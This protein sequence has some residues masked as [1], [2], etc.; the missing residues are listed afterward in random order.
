M[1]VNLRTVMV[2][3][4]TKAFPSIHFCCSMHSARAPVSEMGCIIVRTEQ[5]ATRFIVTISWAAG[6]AN[7]ADCRAA[8][9]EDLFWRGSW[10]AHLQQLTET[11]GCNRAAMRCGVH[12][13]AQA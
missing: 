1:A 13:G 4:Q 8:A 3:K 2:N 6:A 7:L 9:L 5:D 10:E 12:E 11:T